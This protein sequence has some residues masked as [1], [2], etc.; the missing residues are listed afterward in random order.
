MSIILEESQA[1]TPMMQQYL[2]IKTQYRDILLFYRMGDFYELFFDDAIKAA[3]LLDITLTKRGQSAG[4]A[5]PMAGV[6]YHAVDGYLAK[7]I[8]Q[9]ESVAIC[10]QMSDPA[11]SK[12]PVERQVT[13][14]IT[15][16]T[17]SD[18]ALLEERTDNLLVAILHHQNHY[19]IAILDICSGQFTVLQIQGKQA[20]QNELA[21]LKPAELLYSENFPD[22]NELGKITSKRLRPACEFDLKHANKILCQQFNVA[23]LSAFNCDD[24]PIAIAAAGCLIQYVK[25]TQ[26]CALPHIRKISVNRIDEMIIIDA[27]TRRNLEISQTIQDNNK[28]TLSFIIDKTSTPMGSRLLKRWLNLPVRDLIVLNLRQQAIATMIEQHY[29]ENL[30]ELLRNIGDIERIIARIA[31]Q[32]VRPRDLS[33]LQLALQQLPTLHALLKD[34]IDPLTQQL[35]Q[36]IPLFTELLTLLEQALIENPPMIIR[37]GGVIKSGY[38]PELDELRALSENADHYLLDLENQER[39]RTGIATLKVGYNR[40]HGYY[41][42]MS[43]AQAAQAPNNY[44]RRQTLKNV[45]RYITPEL[46]IFEDKALSSQAR[47]LAREK[48]LYEELLAKILPYLEQLQNCA[49]ALAQLD[50]LANL[51]ERAVTL[52]Y[53]K[54]TLT[55]ESGIA[56]TQGRHPVIEQVQTDVFIANDINLTAEQRML[57]ITGPNMGGKSTYMRQIALICLLAY[58]GSYV[59]AQQATIGPIDRIFSRIGA[60]DDLANGRSTFMVE[61]TETAT[62]LHN[63]TINSLVLI[64]E[65]GRGTST[66]DGMALAWACALELAQSLKAYTLFA[67]HY[68][69]LTQ[70]PEQLP[71]V[72]NV[73]LQAVEDHET[74]A[75]LHT[76]KDGP[77]NKSYGLQVAKLAGI[78][79]PVITAAKQKLADLEIHHHQEPITEF[80][81]TENTIIH[82]AIELLKNIDINNL[83]PLQALQFL[84][85]LKNK[86]IQ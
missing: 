34:N 2:R 53:V 63:A 18:A 31:L 54:P 62:I 25:E 11:T 30:Q 86:Y 81:A 15:P 84:E 4:Q 28:Y 1:H 5:I 26:R 39:Q 66:Y 13:R 56:I 85:Q 61:M 50:V 10:E 75:F 35:L 33:N 14:I 29:C 77:A 40:V 59:P 16:G 72:R 51:A 9:G 6:P 73:H 24:L 32:T 76:V 43:R 46:K 38:D 55:C 8:K 22:I 12:G 44:L 19:G 79:I 71:Q 69:E 48:Q 20:L 23:S 70:I 83:T 68:F 7:L 82:P 74:I 47:A 57:I 67:T 41:I 52:R 78:P 36:Q 3:K 65:I 60:S 80:K 21:R 42:E 49:T 58:I 45:E 37:D 27:A 17:V 64:D